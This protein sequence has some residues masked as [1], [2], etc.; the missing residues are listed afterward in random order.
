M[1][2]ERCMTCCSTLIAVTLAK[3]CVVKYNSLQNEGE[4]LLIGSMDPDYH[5]DSAPWCVECLGE[6]E[7]ELSDG[8]GTRIISTDVVTKYEVDELV[9]VRDLNMTGLIVEKIVQCSRADEDFGYYNVLV[10]N[11]IRAV[12]DDCIEGSQ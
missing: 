9:Y 5:E 10:D 4:E 2:L 11:R 6:E 3:K 1:R 8:E 12:F 7:P